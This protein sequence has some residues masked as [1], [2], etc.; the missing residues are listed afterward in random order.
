MKIEASFLGRTFD[1]FMLR[2]QYSPVG[3]GEEVERRKDIDLTMPLTTNRSF[4]LP[5]IS[6][7]MDTVTGQE[8]MRTL[9]LEGA[10]GFL[11]RHCPISQQVS[12]VKHVKRRQSSVIENPLRMSRKATIHDA[13]EFRKKH[14][15]SGILVEEELDN[16]ILA[17]ILS[18]RDMPEDPLFDSKPISEFMTPVKRLVTAGSNMTMEEA[19]ALMFKRRV[20][21]LPLVDRSG[22]I[23]GL[24][25]MKDLRLSKQKPYS[26]KD[27][28]G[29]LLVGAAIGATGD[30]ME[31]AAELIKH[32]V[33]CILIDI[34]HF[35]SVSGKK[36]VETFRSKFGNIDL[37]C[38]NIATADAARFALKLGVNA[39]KVGI[40]PGRGC[41]TRL[42]TSAG[43]PQLQAIREV[44]IAVGEQIPVI[45]DGG[46][47]NDKDIFLAIICGASS[48]MLGSI[49]SG[50]D[51]S[52]GRVIEDPRTRQKKKIY[53]GMT[54]PEAVLGF[55]SD[56]DV[57]DK[58]R[59]PAEGQE[60]E[61]PYV[62]SVVQ[63]L[64]RIQGHL[65]SAVS[66]AGE[67]NLKAAH[68]KIAL[69]PEDF[70]IS[71]SEASKT[72]SFQR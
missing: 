63:V 16:G 56:E 12:R 13:R 60:N 5:I 65:Q 68:R 51:E 45:A 47:R 40:G 64:E 28:R 61:V 43:V 24:I 44:F 67:N 50:T 10:F 18:N 48:V 23:K 8:M 6:A 39:V 58:L 57:E 2:P 69:R 46:V 66:Y 71:L 32:G 1:D 22:K 29:R 7:N 55:S 49:L 20:E 70:L 19:E 59:T 17:G 36:A 11:D 42:E 15:V 14:R 27:K 62:G 4:R 26:T 53:R 52:P 31:R 9:S 35:H 38:G 25:T 3:P 37:V 54:S 30:Y 72:E 21:K 33:D 34:A 41:R